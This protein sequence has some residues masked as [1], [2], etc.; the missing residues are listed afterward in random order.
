MKHLALLL[1]YSLCCYTAQAKSPNVIIILTDDHGFADFAA[2]GLTDDIR[3][4]HLDALAQGGAVV[5][6]GYS[7]APQCIP[8]RAG[9]VTARYQTRFGLGGNKYA[10][11]ALSETTV[12]ERMRDAGYATGFIGKWHLEPNR[13]SRIWMKTGWPEGL[14]QENPR[15]PKA[16]REPY[17]PM[18][19]G[20][21]DYY[22]GAMHGYLRNYDLN[23][24][25]IPREH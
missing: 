19:R 20:F 15:V 9:I 5:T 22:D 10:P 23:G 3:T 17:L 25:E 7:T 24:Q 1:L 12:A 14:E 11:M 13:N 18:N 2:Y 4:P 16:L 6:N 21:S 8:S